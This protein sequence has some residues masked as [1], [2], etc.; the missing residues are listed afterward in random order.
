MNSLLIDSLSPCSYLGL[1]QIVYAKQAVTATAAATAIK[2]HP[3]PQAVR[4][5][6]RSAPLTINVIQ[7]LQNTG[8]SH[9]Q[10]LFALR[11]TP[12][13]LSKTQIL[14]SKLILTCFNP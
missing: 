7:R 1:V 14:D 8:I 11:L 4:A 2:H 10:D 12:T 3:S 9:H 5:S 6:A 13:L